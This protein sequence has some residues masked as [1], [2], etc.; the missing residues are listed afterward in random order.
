GT[1]AV[2]EPKLLSL[3]I[4]LRQ[5]P[6]SLYA[7]S[8]TSFPVSSSPPEWRIAAVDAAQRIARGA[9]LRG[10]AG[11]A[12]ARVKEIGF[13]SARDRATGEMSV[14]ARE[15]ARIDRREIATWSF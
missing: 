14:V 1:V 8:I 4:R 2:L 12:A 13:V 9:L 7:F 10:R 3:T 6:T 15:R 11:I 5:R